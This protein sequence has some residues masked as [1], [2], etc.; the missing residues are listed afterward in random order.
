MEAIL[1]AAREAA[2]MAVVVAGW[3]YFRGVRFGGS[4]CSGLRARVQC[5]FWFSVAVVRGDRRIYDHQTQQEPPRV[6]CYNFCL[7]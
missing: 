1:A 5:G 3:I 2:T 6:R 4:L 7:L